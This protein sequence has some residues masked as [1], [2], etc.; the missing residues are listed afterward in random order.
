[1]LFELS[2]ADLLAGAQN[3]WIIP[4]GILAL[5]FY[6]R[7]HFNSLEYAI[8]FGNSSGTADSVGARLMTPA[9]PIFTTS[10]T[11]YNSFA[12]QYV[13]ILVGAFLAMVFFPNLVAE[14]ITLLTGSSFSFGESMSLQHRALVALFTLTGLL[15]SFPGFKDLDRWLLQRLHR[16]AFI[17]DDV[18]MLAGKLY[19]AEYCPPQAALTEVR[20]TLVSRDAIRAASGTLK[21]TLE[22][23]LIAVLCLRTQLQS[24]LADGKFTGF[25]IKLDRDLREVTNQSLGLRAALMVYLRDQE[26]LVPADAPDVVPIGQWG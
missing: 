4:A 10:R 24:M 5:Y 12:R 14:A 2:A 23:R 6:G 17:P 13:L 22:Q 18:R 15:S 16:A 25:K 20:P 3:Y 11:R 8:D 9:P 1:M 7:F 26:R 21:G 19:N